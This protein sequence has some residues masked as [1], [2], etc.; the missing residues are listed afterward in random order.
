MQHSSAE[1]VIGI[2]HNH[3]GPEIFRANGSGETRATATRDDDVHLVVPD[4]IFGARRGLRLG[5]PRLY[6][7]SCTQS[8]GGSGLD[9][10]PPAETFVVL[11]SRIVSRIVAFHGHVSPPNNSHR[12]LL[13]GTRCP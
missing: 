4:D 13:A 11:E 7:G 12:C 1:V 2:D 9:E 10:V 3:A 6:Q 5:A 8:D